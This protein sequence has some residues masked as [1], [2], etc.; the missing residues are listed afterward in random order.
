M[1]DRKKRNHSLRACLGRIGPFIRSRRAAAGWALFCAALIVALAFSNAFVCYAVS[2][3]GRDVGAAESRD[4]L[5]EAVE[6]AEQQASKILGRSCSLTGAVTVTAELGRGWDDASALA[7]RIVENVS[8]ISRL[9]VLRVDGAA[10][11][12]M[13]DETALR[14]ILA[15]VLDRYTTSATT[16]AA[17][18]QNVTVESQLV[19]DEIERDPEK[20][21]AL[22]SPGSGSGCALS[23]ITCEDGSGTEVIAHGT[24]TVSDDTMRA[25][26]SATLAE[27][28]D[29]LRSVAYTVTKVNGVETDRKVTSAAV[30]AEPTDTLVSVGTR[31]VLPTDSTGTYIMPA[32]GT[33]TSYF[34]YRSVSVGSTYHK[35]LDIGGAYGSDI[36]AA[37]GGTVIFAEWYSGYGYLM[38]VQHDNGDV[39]YYGHLSGFVASV[40]DKVA[41]GQVIAYM[42]CSGVASGTHVHFEIRPGG[43]DPVDPLPYVSAN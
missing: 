13:E 43:G 1:T 16:Y 22:L 36:V 40:G 14:A 6:S 30:T 28:S 11:G 2:V 26:E 15:S 23:V 8:G 3:D 39:T 32:E 42:G 34:G 21:A 41:Q 35:G 31:E 29:G 5:T 9:Y 12:A 25:G 20:I 24:K 17:F 33:I 38:Q 19:S 37:D 10:V 18:G 4:D 27:G 7:S